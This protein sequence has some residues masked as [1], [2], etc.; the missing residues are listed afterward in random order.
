MVLGNRKG[1][2]VRSRNNK[3]KMNKVRFVRGKGI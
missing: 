1:F 2:K 3:Y